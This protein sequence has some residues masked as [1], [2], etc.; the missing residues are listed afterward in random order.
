[1]QSSP[2]FFLGLGLKKIKLPATEVVVIENAPLG[3]QSAK[4][5]GLKVV[6]LK[7]GLV[8]IRDLKKCKPDLVFKDC[9]EVLKNLSKGKLA[10]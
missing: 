4:S 6:A 5:A 1:M 7:T 2:K 8:S 10:V 9:A 3:I